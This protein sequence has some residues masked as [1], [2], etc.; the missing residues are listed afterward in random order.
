MNSKLSVI[1]ESAD[2][3]KAYYDLVE[4]YKN[5]TETDREYIRNNWD[6]GKEWIY[7]DPTKLACLLPDEPSNLTRICASLTYYAIAGQSK[8]FR[9]NLIDYCVIYNS[10]LDMRLDAR[11]IFMDIAR[12][13]LPSIASGFASF[14]NRADEDKAPGAFGWKK[15]VVGDNC[16]I[17]I[18]DL[19][20]V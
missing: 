2:Y 1:L 16:V 13:S 7:P 12:I 14:I 17:Y 8:D 19:L 18:L 3:K 10:A 11:E 5:S 15:T 9:E 6:F 4:L 20:D